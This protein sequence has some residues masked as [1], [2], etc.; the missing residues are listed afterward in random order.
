MWRYRIESDDQSEVTEGYLDDPSG[1]T[2]LHFEIQGKS[3]EEERV[4]I[5]RV[6]NLINEG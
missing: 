1:R 3:P 6:V 2:V 4:L 5:H